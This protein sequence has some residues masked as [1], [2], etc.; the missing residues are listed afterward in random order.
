M[1]TMSTAVYLFLAFQI[2]RKHNLIQD[3]QVHNLTFGERY[4]DC[5][6]SP[7][8]FLPC[9]IVVQQNIVT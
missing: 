5:K 2:V 4:E 8:D 1:H 3:C 9:I 7:A 6:P